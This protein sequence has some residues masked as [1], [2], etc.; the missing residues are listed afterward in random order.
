M[1]ACLNGGLYIQLKLRQENVHWRRV[2]SLSL[3]NRRRG[4]QRCET[5]SQ[6]VPNP[7]R[8]YGHMK[9]PH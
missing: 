1:R 5:S 6:V 8:G 3:S 9:G 4:W 2:D 7:V